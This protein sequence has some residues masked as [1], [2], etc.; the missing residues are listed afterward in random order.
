V[1]CVYDAKHLYINGDAF[2]MM[3]DGDFWRALADVREATVSEALARET[4]DALYEWYREGWLHV[5]A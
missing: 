2:V 1:Q 3:G 5:H 4:V